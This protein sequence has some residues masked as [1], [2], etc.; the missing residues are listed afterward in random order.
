VFG[1]WDSFVPA[2]LPVVA[3][4]DW[5]SAYLGAASSE[6]RIKIRVIVMALLKQDFF[7]RPTI[8]VAQDLLG[9]KLLREYNGSILSGMITETE[10]YLGAGD[11]AC[12]AA[13]GRTP[14]NSVMF[15]PA[16]VAYV[17][18]VYGMHF[19]LNIVTEQEETPCAVLIRAMKPLAG[20][21]QMQDLRGKKGREVGNGPAKLCQAMAID[22]S[23]NG[24]DITQGRVLWLESH[25]K[26][27]PD[28]INSGPRIGIAY[29]ARKDRD[30]PLRFWTTK[31]D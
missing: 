30:A 5:Q 12:H 23:L 17:Y 31:G 26:L 24:W 2:D 15:G 11:S 9:T 10:A 29:A 22:K 6:I 1:V 25:L 13:R 3:D 21:A 27:I 28:S 4:S 8:T 7:R 20:L 16:G 19:M 14:R 18:F